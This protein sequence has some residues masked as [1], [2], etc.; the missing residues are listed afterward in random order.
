MLKNESLVNEILQLASTILVSSTRRR[1]AAHCPTLRLTTATAFGPSL[2][3]ALSLARVTSTK[4]QSRGSRIR[5]RPCSYYPR[6]LLEPTTIPYLEPNIA[7]T[8]LAG[9]CLARTH[10]TLRSVL[11]LTRSLSPACTSASPRST[12]V[13]PAMEAFNPRTPMMLLFLGMSH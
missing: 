9:C 2:P 4:P 13:L 3:P 7:R 10:Q 12:T 8:K 6:T 5:V 11:A 1:T